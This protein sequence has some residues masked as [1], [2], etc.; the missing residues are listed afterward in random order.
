MYCDPVPQG[1]GT[2][3]ERQSLLSWVSGNKVFEE[4]KTTQRVGITEQSPKQRLRMLLCML[5]IYSL[6]IWHLL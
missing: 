5:I 4:W 3:K 2:S 1:R 6:I